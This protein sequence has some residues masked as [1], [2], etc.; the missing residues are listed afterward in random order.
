MAPV[1]KILLINPNSSQEMTENLKP[2]VQQY[3]S[4]T[5]IETYTA[6]ADSPKSIN[7][8]EDALASAK[9]VYPEIL[10]Y[11]AKKRYD[12]YLVA[13]Y[14]LHPL[15]DMIR[16]AAPRGIYVTGI[17][18]ASITT[19]LALT[20]GRKP[21]SVDLPL[22]RTK[23]GIVTTGAAWEKALSEGVMNVI[24]LNSIIH[25]TRFKG[26][27][28][29][30]LNADELH[31]APKEFVRKKMKEATKRLVQGND[32]KVISL[33]CAGMSGLDQIVQEALIEELGEEDAREVHILDPVK[34]GIGMLE[35][36]LK[37]L[38]GSKSE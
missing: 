13:C 1:Y 4:N 15:V 2:L 8:E 29:T 7:N 30:G 19:A 25:S 12:G 3:P 27:E 34:V 31:T 35:N 33:G 22:Q 20:P 24:G 17:F 11:I 21:R 26:V 36:V 5:V 28:S 23:F 16:E 37:S 32:V 14:S 6:P 18:E 10:Q 38:P 9:V